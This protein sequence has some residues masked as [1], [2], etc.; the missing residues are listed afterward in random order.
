[1]TMIVEQIKRARRAAKAAGASMVWRRDRGEGVVRF[2]F[3]EGGGRI[4]VEYP[5]S[6][7]GEINLEKAIDEL[8]EI[9]RRMIR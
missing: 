3:R 5:N 9:A 7:Q 4:T 2:Y 8:N 1:M 6:V